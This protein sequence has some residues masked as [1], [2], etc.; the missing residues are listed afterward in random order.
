MKDVK[1]FRWRR[2]KNLLFPDM[3]LKPDVEVF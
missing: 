3:N 2:K 1:C